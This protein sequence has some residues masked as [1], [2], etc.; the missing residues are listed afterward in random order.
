[1][2]DEGFDEVSKALAAPH[3]RRQALKLFGATAVGGLVSLIGVG[4]ASAADPG[5]CRRAGQ[6]CRRSS[7][8]CSGIC[9]PSGTCACPPPK[10][11]DR[12]GH[13]VC[14]ADTET[15]GR[16]TEYAQCCTSTQEC[17]N[18]GFS[19]YCC[20]GNCCYGTGTYSGSVS[21]CPEGTACCR[22][23]SGQFAG[24]PLCCPTGTTCQPTSPYCGV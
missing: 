2:G 9:S 24:Y 7:E 5:R 3:T 1:M 13:C 22:I 8:C 16:Y 23:P 18:A 10:V 19:Q 4:R 6:G 17:C 11:P 14:P 21:C 12:Q 20:N 15:C